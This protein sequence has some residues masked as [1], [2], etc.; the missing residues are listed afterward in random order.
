MHAKV[1]YLR[2]DDRSIPGF[3]W[4]NRI[5]AELTPEQR[6]ENGFG[7]NPFGTVPNTMVETKD[8]GIGASYV[9]DKGYFGASYTRFF[10]NTACPDDPEVDEPAVPPARVHLDGAQGPIQ[11]AQLGH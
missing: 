6:H 11:R 1:L 4:I 7:E 5:R 8:F 2:T 9:W 10:P 3:A